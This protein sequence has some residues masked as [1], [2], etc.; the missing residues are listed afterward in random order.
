[1]EQKD[2]FNKIEILLEE[3]QAAILATADSRGRAYVRWMTPVFLKNRPGIIYTFT[4]PNSAKAGQIEEGSDAE[5]MIQNKAL[6]EIVNVRGGINV[7]DNPALKNEL[8]EVIGPK[9]MM[10]WKANEQINEF[11]VLE[12]IMETA[13]YYQ[14]MKGTKE[15]IVINRE[16]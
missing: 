14:P 4:A 11:V 15:T 7:I 2:L 10:F 16:P 5:W 6:T 3:S 13:I 9:L 8:F 1:M 12:T